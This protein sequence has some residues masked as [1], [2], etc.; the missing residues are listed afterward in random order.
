MWVRNVSENM[1]LKTI[2]WASPPGSL[3]LPED[4]IHIWRVDLDPESPSMESLKAHLSSDELIRAR[5]FYFKREHDRFIV[6]RGILRVILGK[7]LSI[8]PG[9]IRFSYGMFGKPA[10]DMH[11]HESR[12]CFNVSHSNGLAIVA[13]TWDRSIGIDIENNRPIPEAQDMADRF[14]SP[15]ESKTLACYSENKKSEVF[16]RYWT[17]KEARIKA[18]GAGLFGRLNQADISLSQ[19][20]LPEPTGMK[21][22]DQRIPGW[23]LLDVFPDP[24]YLA[25]LVV[26]GKEL[27]LLFWEA[28][29]RKNNL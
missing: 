9:Q 29:S 28:A 1:A 21:N 27:P 24:D 16:L 20:A 15:G 23:S 26:Q 22:E 5:R 8:D 18:G 25:A 6:C 19:E 7:Y 13:I 4:I 12:L 17:R 10:L 3:R 2:R 14:L 11:V